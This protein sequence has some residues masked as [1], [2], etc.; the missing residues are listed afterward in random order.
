MPRCDLF[1]KISFLRLLLPYSSLCTAWKEK[2]NNRMY[3]FIRQGK[4]L[5]RNTKRWEKTYY[6]NIKEKID[7]TGVQHDDGP[8]NLQTENTNVILLKKPDALYVSCSNIH[9]IPFSS[10]NMEL[11][12]FSTNLT[13]PRILP[14]LREFNLI[15]LQRASWDLNSSLV[16]A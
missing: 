5:G 11:Y 10:M 3:G 1:L 15:A 8:E 6:S 12:P 14:F 16:S 9:S 13:P 4:R 7:W 2:S